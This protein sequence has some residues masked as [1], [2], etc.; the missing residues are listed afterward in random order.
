MPLV[1]TKITGSNNQFS[2]LN[3][4]LIYLNINGLNSLIKRHRLKDW[5]HKQDPK[6]CCRQEIHISDKD[7]HSLRGKGWNTI[8]QTNGPTKQA[9]IAIL[10]FK[11]DRLSTKSYQKG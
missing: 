8:F 9:G 6:F 4:F 10:I 5:I 11:K 2:S 7:R 3:F 1:T